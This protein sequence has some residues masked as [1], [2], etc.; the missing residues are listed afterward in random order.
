MYYIYINIYISV[1]IETESLSLFKPV[2]MAR[3]DI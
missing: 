2:P 1:T 3:M